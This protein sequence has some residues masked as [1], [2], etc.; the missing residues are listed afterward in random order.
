MTMELRGGV[1]V[2][3][4]DEYEAMPELD[5]G[6]REAL[7]RNVVLRLVRAYHRSQVTRPW[8]GETETPPEAEIRADA[9]QRLQRAMAHAHRQWPGLT[10]CANVVEDAPADVLVRESQQADVTVLGSRHLGPVGALLLGSVSNAVITRARGPV[11]VVRNAGRVPVARPAVVVGLDGSPGTEDVLRFAFDHA[12]RHHRSLEA[13]VCVAESLEQRLAGA[14]TTALADHAG[15]WL[16]ATVAPWHTRYAG[17]E[18]RETVAV[19]RPVAGLVA[20]SVGQELLVVGGSPGTG[21]FLG[22]VTQGLLHHADCPVAVVP[23]AP[24]S[25]HER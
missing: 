1:V 15:H 24:A 2:G 23:S 18:L 16:A 17:I 11:V 7:A 12:A 19:S 14:S 13:I 20:A 5:W 22:S 21:A 9:L 4:G 25:A 6:G 10:V 3:V 8:Q